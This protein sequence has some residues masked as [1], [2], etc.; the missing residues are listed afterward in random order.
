MAVIK[1]QMKPEGVNDFL[2]VIHHETDAD[3]VLD[4]ASKVLMLPAERTK[5][6]GISIN[7]NNYVHPTTHPASMITDMPTNAYQIQLADAGGN[8]AATNVEAGMTELFTNVSNGKIVVAAAIADKGVASSSSD[9]F[10]TMATKIGTITTQ[11]F[12]TGNA[13]AGNVL[14]GKTFYSTNP[15]S[16]LTGTIPS[17]SAATYTPTTFSQSVPAGNYLSGAQTIL[18]DSDLVAANIKS[19][20][21]IFGVVG[22]DTVP[23]VHVGAIDER[24]SGISLTIDT[25]WLPKQ[26]FAFLYASGDLEAMLVYDANISTSEW[27]LYFYVSPSGTWETRSVSYSSGYVDSG[28]ARF[29]YV[30]SSTYVRDL[31]WYAISY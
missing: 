13:I 28:G 7:A 23:K 14:S 10:S 3:M 4:T 26:I 29:S 30:Q 22:I 15:S 21:N 31:T 24:F 27:Y 18:G 16:K 12:L 1:V 17:K 6:S 19:G 5:L 11:S 8:F 25:P 20:V 2:D 9:T